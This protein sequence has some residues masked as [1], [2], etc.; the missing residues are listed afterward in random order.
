MFTSVCNHILGDI[1][2]VQIPGRAR[3][4]FALQPSEEAQRVMYAPSGPQAQVVQWDTQLLM[5]LTWPTQDIH[6][7]A[8]PCNLLDFNLSGL[9][10]LVPI[11]H[12]RGNSQNSVMIRLSVL[13]HSPSHYT[14]SF[15]LCLHYFNDTL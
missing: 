10:S 15:R 7:G 12:M 11:I 8:P 14:V 4:A 9:N 6:Q 2:A 3:G 5:I 13:L 1:I